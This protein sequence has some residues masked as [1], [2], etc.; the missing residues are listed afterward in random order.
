LT[1][2]IERIANRY[3]VELTCLPSGVPSPSALHMTLQALLD[4]GYSDVGARLRVLR[5]IT[6]HRLYMLDCEQAAPLEVVMQGMTD[7]AE[8]C[9]SVAAQTAHAEL[10]AKHGAP[11][12]RGQPSTLWTVG[13]GKLGARELN[14]SS[15]IDLIYV[16]DKDGE[17]LANQP[18]QVSTS[19]HDFFAKQV[20]RMQS[21]LADVTQHG[22][23]FRV[24]LALRPYGS[25][26]ALAISLST[27]AQYFQ[28]SG[29]EWE[30]FAWLKSRVIQTQAVLQDVL[31]LRAVVRSFVFRRFLDFKVF[32]ALQGLHQLIR[33]HADSSSGARDVKLGRGGIREIEF[34]AQ[35]LQ[36]VRGGR[37]PELLARPTLTALERLTAAGLMDLQTAESLRVAYIF[38]RKLEHR[39][40]YLDDAQTHRVPTQADDLSWVAQQ[41]GF[42]GTEAFE[43]R[44]N[45]HTD[46][47]AIFF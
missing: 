39:I 26:G 29:R 8:V 47:V 20:R 33:K 38:L 46:A 44:L 42:T 41:M 4:M 18:A 3:P 15:D 16:Y 36:I 6:L 7:L 40:Q 25:E 13:M 12:A 30:R 22:F 10:V 43:A 32:T 1:R 28:R 11:M 35:V 31:P 34:A 14:V 9:L 21:L 23:V 5:Q 27:L 17:T 45:Q 37:Q 24:D 2:A 19:N